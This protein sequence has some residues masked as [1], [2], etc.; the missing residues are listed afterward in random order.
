SNDLLRADLQRDLVRR[1]FPQMAG[2]QHHDTASPIRAWS[3]PQC[4]KT[5]S[6]FQTR[7]LPPNMQWPAVY[8]PS[9]TPVCQGESALVPHDPAFPVPSPLRVRPQVHSLPRLLSP[10]RPTLVLSPHSP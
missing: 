7:L 6:G 10:S 9:A 8:L 1:D 4:Y 2:R 5:A 3:P